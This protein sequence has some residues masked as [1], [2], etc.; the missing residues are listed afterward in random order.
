MAPLNFITWPWGRGNRAVN[1]QH[2]SD[3]KLCS[4]CIYPW[5]VTGL[6]GPCHS[7]VYQIL[8]SESDTQTLGGGGGQ[9]CLYEFFLKNQFSKI[10]NTHIVCSPLEWNSEVCITKA[11][12]A[13]YLV[14]HWVTQ[15]EENKLGDRFWHQK[16]KV[17]L[18]YSTSGKRNINPSINML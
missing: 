18:S 8:I 1:C 5:S 3:S 10:C 2:L 14:L 7:T 16:M 4:N 15:T 6:T 11:R 12:G 17:N 9:N 13:L